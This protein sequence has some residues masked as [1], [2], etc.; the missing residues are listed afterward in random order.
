M[1]SKHLA[2]SRKWM[3]VI[4]ILTLFTLLLSACGSADPLYGKWIEPNSGVQI[5]IKNNG[6]FLLTMNGRTFTLKYTLEA[7]NALILAGSKDGSVPDMRLIY[8]ATQDTLTI[9]ASG[10]DTIFKRQK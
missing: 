4:A 8:T 1:S 3:R 10:V 5:E 7:P 9:N 2:T 6:D